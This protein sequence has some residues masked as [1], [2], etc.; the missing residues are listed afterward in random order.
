MCKSTLIMLLSVLSIPTVG[1]S[2]VAG[3]H[4]PTDSIVPQTQELSNCGDK[5]KQCDRGIG[6]R[7]EQFSKATPD[8]DTTIKERGSGR[9]GADPSTKQGR[10]SGRDEDK[11]PEESA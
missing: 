11:A 9:F 10:G 1:F 7:D 4:Q 6:R 8:L 2:T 3:A 5:T